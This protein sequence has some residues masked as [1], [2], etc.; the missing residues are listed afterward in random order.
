MNQILI[1][2][3]VSDVNR[4]QYNTSLKTNSAN[5]YSEITSLPDSAIEI[6]KNRVVV[7]G[8]ADNADEEKATI[9][10]ND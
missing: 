10:T 6:V 2:P 4:V 8:I 5:Y 9:I 3:P 1:K 7:Y